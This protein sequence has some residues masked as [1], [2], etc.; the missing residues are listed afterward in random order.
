MVSED[1]ALLRETVQ[2]AVREGKTILATTDL[3][4]QLSSSEE[5]C[6]NINS[7]AQNQ[8]RIADDVLAL[9]RIN[10]DMMQFHY[11]SLQEQ[12]SP[13]ANVTNDTRLMISTATNPYQETRKRCGC[14]V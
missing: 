6:H 2:R 5:L 7:C 13:K 8:S 4:N 3:I 9:A 10:L 1:L 11:V 14:T 12:S